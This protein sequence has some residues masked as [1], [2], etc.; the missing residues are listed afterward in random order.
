VLGRTNNEFSGDALF[1][2][3][4]EMIAEFSDVHPSRIAA[5]LLCAAALAHE[6]FVNRRYK[7]RFVLDIPA[8]ET[9]EIMSARPGF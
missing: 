7:G 5:S 6:L 2:H 3:K 8:E 4:R 9:W 1:E